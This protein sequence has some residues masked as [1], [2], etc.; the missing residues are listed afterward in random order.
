MITRFFLW[1]KYIAFHRPSFKKTIISD[2]QFW[3]EETS[4]IK[5]FNRLY[6]RYILY[7]I[8][9]SLK[10]FSERRQVL[11]TFGKYKSQGMDRYM[12]GRSV[13]R[14]LHEAVKL[15]EITI[16]YTQNKKG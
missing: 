11:W 14:T 2:E 1:S 15:A 4:F 3:N 10:T 9:L 12:K 7:K 5:A 16:Y 8:L 13:D 6:F